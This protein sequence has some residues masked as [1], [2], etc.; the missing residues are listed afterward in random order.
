MKIKITTLGCRNNQYES[1]EIQASF[2]KEG[3]QPVTF[4]KKA[5]I[6]VINTCSVTEK[7][8]Y[9]CRQLI[10]KAVDSNPESA[11]V[12]VGC[13][14]QLD[15]QAIKSL[16]GVDL[17]LGNEEKLDTL[18]FLK[19]LKLLQNIPLY[20]E[21]QFTPRVIVGKPEMGSLFRSVDVNHFSGKTK[22]YLKVQTGCNYK[23]SFCVITLARGKSRSDSPTEVVEKFKRLL[24]NGFKEIALTG[25]HL[26]SYGK[27][28]SPSISLNELLRLLIK[29]KGDF[30][31]RLGS[32]GPSDIND[33][34]IE[35]ISDSPKICNHLHISLQSGSNKIL[36]L[37]KRNYRMEY[38]SDLINK[39][40]SRIP[41]IGLGADVIA[42][43]PGETD[44]DFEQTL[45]FIKK[46]PFSYLHVFNFSRRKNTDAYDLPDQISPQIRKN[47][48][49]ILKELS[50][51]KSI[52]F[53]EKLLEKKIDVLVEHK[54][55]QNTKMLK[56]YTGNYL[57]VHFS[58]SD[59]SINKILPV[60]ISHIENDIL[61]GA[62]L[63]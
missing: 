46:N 8:N 4:D 50:I 43:F 45:S 22:A 2:E 34:L 5:D 30:R 44:K 16:P 19:K 3:F 47:R 56:G 49:S 38:F 36:R 62:V 15:S 29:V 10:R 26:G 58:G 7:S 11:I 12:V 23:C 21:K 20:K 54:R 52:N 17:I 1:A 33:E 42:G 51:Q 57:S 14:S 60:H 6:C 24:G 61:Y 28:L 55:D 31:I 53:K 48:V 9:K 39:I 63:N 32:L 18:K 41:E 37:M 13:Y 40:T 25:I 27:G 35:L 59:R